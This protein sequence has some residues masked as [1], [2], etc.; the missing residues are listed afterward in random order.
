MTTT[1]ARWV[2]MAGTWV[3]AAVFVALGGLSQAWPTAALY[4][5]LFVAVLTLFEV[6]VGAATK[7]EA[8]PGD[9]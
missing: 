8:P 9:G 3:I 2:S 6:G 7:S 1:T 4:I 5:L